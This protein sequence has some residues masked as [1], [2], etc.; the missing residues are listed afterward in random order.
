MILANMHTHT[1]YCGHAQGSVKEL[2]DAA[3]N[4]NISYLGITEHYPLSKKFDPETFL[5]MPAE[6]MDAYQADVLKARTLYDDIEI[7][8]GCELDWLGEDEDRCFDRIEL[9]RF[10]LILGSVHFIDGWAFDDPAQKDRWLDE[11]PDYI[12]RRYFDVWCDAVL[13]DQPFTIMAHPDLCK[14]FGH[15]PSFD[16]LPLY[17][18]AA[19][20]AREAD[21][22]IEVNTS[23]AFYPCA[24]MYPAPALLNEF[25]RA[26]V[27]CSIGTDAHT[28]SHCAR[29]LTEGI[30]LMYE[31]GYREITV[32]T[33]TQDRRAIIIE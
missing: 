21:R 18:N 16:P 20:A 27:K 19:E 11:G 1:N 25:K 12:W 31:S 23:G 26:G 24:E 30:A 7:L 2:V 3:R 33:M 22:L 5:S 10:D 14:K 13:S 17:K 8:F 4:K 15:R 6:N 28:P 9:E 32:P 29:A